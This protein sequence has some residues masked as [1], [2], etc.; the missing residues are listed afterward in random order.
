MKQNIKISK[1]FYGLLIFVLA[2]FCFILV[3]SIKV[4][5]DATFLKQEYLFRERAID[6]AENRLK[7][8]VE[9]KLEFMEL[10]EKRAVET[11]R[12]ELKRRVEEGWRVA[13][14]IHDTFEGKESEKEIQKRVVRAL[15]E[16]HSDNYGYYY[17]I[18]F[19]GEVILH[20]FWESAKKQGAKGS[21]AS[22]NKALLKNQ[23]DL[24]KRFEE[25]YSAGYVKEEFPSEISKTMGLT[26]VK[27]FKNQ[28]WYIGM[29]I[30]ESEFKKQVQ[31]TV[32]KEVQTF[33]KDNWDK[34]NVSV[35]DE[36]H[37]KLIKSNRC[38]FSETEK[39][40]LSKT[41]LKENLFGG[42]ERKEIDVD[43]K[44]TDVF[45]YALPWEVWGW[46]FVGEDTIMPSYPYTGKY[47]A[48]EVFDKV[49]NQSLVLYGAIVVLALLLGL[50]I[51]RRLHIGFSKMKNWVES[52]KQ[53]EIEENKHFKHFKEFFDIF[54][55][56]QQSQNRGE[57][58]H[59][60]AISHGMDE[61]KI[62]Y[63]S[64]SLTRHIQ[65]EMDNICEDNPDFELNVRFLWEK[66]I[67][68]RADRYIFSEI[69]QTLS[70]NSIRH[71]FFGQMKGNVTVEV[72]QEENWLHLHFSDNGWGMAT[73]VQDTI[74]NE[75]H[76]E[77]SSGLKRVHYL[78]TEILGGNMQCSGYE[79]HGTD[80]H[81][82]IPAA[83]PGLWIETDTR[84]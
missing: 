23:I 62:S 39:I 7:N 57:K 3:V 28:D 19:D 24:V 55:A 22:Y 9:E 68:V 79:G 56:I 21:N 58:L 26:Y 35:F 34:G 38:L 46:V 80:I 42:F 59:K 53:Y 61:K 16:L 13:A 83:G 54:R 52:G 81:L 14:Y 1:A 27:R 11:M 10:S 30:Y 31:D 44:K 15:Q 29:G 25:G 67:F 71:G 73:Q 20:P 70:E 82:G 18:N 45:L 77:N 75:L 78:V 12:I 64:F 4:R 50:S 5:M 17:M 76:Q 66:N 69:L 72:V 43:G 48:K 47:Y 37:R 32:L 60:R 49:Y 51:N 40:N 36:K 2:T 84:G 6:Q 41:I 65:R 33:E 63:K 8:R 74:F